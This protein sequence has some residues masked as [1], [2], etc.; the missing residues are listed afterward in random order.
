MDA[1]TVVVGSG[2][3]GLSAA[4]FLSSGDKVIVVD[5]LDGDRYDRYHSICGEGISEDAFAS[6][7]PIE[8]WHIRNRI[9]GTTLIWPDGTEIHVP[10]RGYILDRPG[11]QRELRRRCEEKG[12][13]F[14][15]GRVTGVAETDEGYRVT[16]SDGRTME[17]G[18]IIGADGAFS[19]VRKELFGT[20]PRICEPVKHYITE[21]ETDRDLIVHLDEKYHGTYK[22]VFPSGDK[23]SVGF[24]KEYD[25]LDEYVSEGARY[26]PFGGVGKIVKGNAYLVGDAAAMTNPISFGGLRVAMLSGKKA[27]EAI[28]AGRP[29]RYRRWWKRSILS[30]KRFMW[31][32]EKLKGWSNED[33]TAAVRPFKNGRLVPSALWA[34]VSRPWNIG[35]Y[36]GCL[37]AFKFTW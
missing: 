23:S 32:H 11:F 19:I 3:A 37:F 4:F 20:E 9:R 21:K 7:S 34:I 2:P 36:I 17:C 24:A 10:C 26:I 14:I 8:P 12:A 13:V 6:I 15:S 35:M 22:W 27:A 29:S 31:F 30:S 25:A 28:L 5:R 1:D 18:N 33:M 16:L